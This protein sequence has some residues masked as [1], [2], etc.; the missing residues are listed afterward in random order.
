[1]GNTQL[2]RALFPHRERSGHY[3]E[4]PQDFDWEAATEKALH[5]DQT[6]RVRLSRTR[7]NMLHAFLSKSPPP[8][9][10]EPAGEWE[11]RWYSKWRERFPDFTPADVPFT[12][13]KRDNYSFDIFLDDRTFG[14]TAYSFGGSSC[15]TVLEHAINEKLPCVKL[16][17]R[18]WEFNNHKRLTKQR[19][20]H[21]LPRPSSS[22]GLSRQ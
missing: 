17:V 5:H 9:G 18:W 13:D 11:K 7:M 1:M 14:A 3:E 2:K 6:Q 4:A 8:P 20:R 19:S 12:I 16:L 22:Y 10:K 21:L 15:P